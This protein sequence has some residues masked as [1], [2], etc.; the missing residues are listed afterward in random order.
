MGVAA[1][2]YVFI[3][4]PTVREKAI[5]ILAVCLL[6]ALEIV[7]IYRERNRQD[8]E[9]AAL[10][11]SAEQRFRET[12]K[13]FDE[14]R[15][16]HESHSDSLLRLMRSM[17]DPIH[18][19]KR[20]AHELSDRIIRFAQ[21]RLEHSY[22]TPS[23][24]IPKHSKETQ[25]QAQTFSQMFSSLL[26]PKMVKKPTALESYREIARDYEL[27]TLFNYRKLFLKE[28]E[29]IRNELSQKGLSEPELDAS[30]KDPPDSSYIR[31]I[32]DWIGALGDR[33]TADS[34]PLP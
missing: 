1:F 13:H 28:V 33:V 6:A 17:N 23:L 31:K 34:R 15:V 7:V 10:R 21:E 8:A 19:L 4:Q 2:A 16:I 12:L 18:G 20:R 22:Y 24:P 9:A 30:Y 3:Q 29:G 27:E 32:G 26:E 11:E 14:L 25:A 5:W